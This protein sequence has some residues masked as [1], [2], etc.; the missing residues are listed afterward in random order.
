MTVS[1]SGEIHYCDPKGEDGEYSD[2]DR[3][4]TI[5]LHGKDALLPESLDHR[6]SPE[7]LKDHHKRHD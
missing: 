3:V 6:P 4:M 2:S 1:K 7:S 5:D